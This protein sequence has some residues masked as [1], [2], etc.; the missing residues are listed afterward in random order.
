MGSPTRWV[1]GLLLDYDL[2]SLYPELESIEQSTIS[3]QLRRA[4]GQEKNPTISVK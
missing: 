1:G 3:N 2:S 4:N